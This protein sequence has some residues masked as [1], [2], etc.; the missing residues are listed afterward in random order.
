[1]IM[2]SKGKPFDAER[3]LGRKDF[4]MTEITDF[5][6]DDVSLFGKTFGFSISVDKKRVIL[7]KRRGTASHPWKIIAE[8][9][10]EKL[11]SI[12]KVD[13]IANE[14]SGMLIGAGSVTQIGYG[15]GTGVKNAMQKAK[16]KRQTGIILELAWVQEPE[17]FIEM[18]DGKRRLQIIECVRQIFEGRS[19][20]VRMAS[21]PSEVKNSFPTQAMLDDRKREQKKKLRRFLV[22]GSG[23]LALIVIILIAV[24][25]EQHAEAARGNYL[26]DLHRNPALVGSPSSG[27]CDF[28]REGYDSILSL[29]GD[30]V[31]HV[32]NANVAMREFADE[33]KDNYILN[34]KR[35][36]LIVTIDEAN[37]TFKISRNSDEFT[38]PLPANVT[39]PLPLP[40]RKGLF[41]PLV[42]PPC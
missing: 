29:E 28:Y 7:F 5:E 35:R 31:T 36:M 27:S 15:V 3:C 42:E 19:P 6:N 26:R 17:I 12:S 41:I 30:G 11:R 9:P 13:G 20:D 2:I 34:F 24:G 10:I 23:T 4:A 38:A 1:M 33:L 22:F 39:Q 40:D 37:K 16:A 21:I 14:A 32:T 25:N 18:Q 8:L